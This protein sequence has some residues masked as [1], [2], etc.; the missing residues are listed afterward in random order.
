M[1]AMKIL[2]LFAGYQRIV[3]ELDVSGDVAVLDGAILE[4]LQ[5]KARATGCIAARTA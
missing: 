3:V 2:Y 4:R 1:P 5:E